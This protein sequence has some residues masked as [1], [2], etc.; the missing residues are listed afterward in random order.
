M[1]LAADLVLGEGLNGGWG[2]WLVAAL[3]FLA[4]DK[5]FAEFFFLWSA[6]GGNGG[7]NCHRIG[8]IVSYFIGVD[9]DKRGLVKAW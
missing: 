9:G 2:C 4:V 3:V 1:F 7:P 8:G 5:S 6:V